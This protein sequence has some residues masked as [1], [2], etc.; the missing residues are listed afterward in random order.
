[1]L[2]KSKNASQDRGAQYSTGTLYRSYNADQV[3]KLG[4]KERRVKTH[5]L[6]ETLKPKAAAPHLAR[7]PPASARLSVT[8]DSY[9]V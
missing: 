1:V 4:P 6:K 5:S 7:A 3:K 9:G 2:P 8:F